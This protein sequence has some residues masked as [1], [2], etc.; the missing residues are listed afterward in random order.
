VA[1][2]VYVEE[3]AYKE[4][5]EIPGIPIGAVMSRLSRVR[6]MLREQL[7]DVARSYGIGS[8]AQEGGRV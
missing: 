2:L 8:P 6:K 3:F 1:L 4:A 5:S 7:V